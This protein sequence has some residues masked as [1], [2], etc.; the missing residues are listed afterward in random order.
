MKHTT[1]LECIPK[2][3]KQPLAGVHAHLIMTPPERTEMVKQGHLEHQGMREAAV[4]ML[5]YPKDTVTH[6][7]LILRSQ[8]IGVHASQVA[9]PGGK[10]EREDASLHHTALWETEEEIGIPSQK[11]TIVKPYSSVYIPPSN[12][13]VYPFMGYCTEEI[14]FVLDS[15]EVAGIIEWNIE[16]LMK[17]SN[18][19]IKKVVT[20]YGEVHV[21]G[22]QIKEYFVWGATAMLLS[23]LKESIKNV[24]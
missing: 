9:F 14:S 24:L 19:V 1:F 23:E 4:L 16:E 18:K 2:L 21:P 15:R 13:C 8:Y 12:F 20:S 17:N 7:V 3:V 10:I 6:L 22:F 5:F 11:I